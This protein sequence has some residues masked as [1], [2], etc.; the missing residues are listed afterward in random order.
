MGSNSRNS[1]TDRTLN[2]PDRTRPVVPTVAAANHQSDA[3]SVRSPATGRVRSQFR[4]PGT[5]LYSIGR[6]VSASGRLP[7]V[8]S[9][10][11]RSPVCRATGPAS[12]RTSSVR[13][14]RPVASASSFLHDLAYGLVP[15]FMLGLGLIF[16]V[17]SCASKVLLEVLI[18]RSSRH[19]RPSH[20]LHPIRLQN[21]HLQIH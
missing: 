5:S 9:P 11:V 20:V 16:W 13:S 10:C 1:A 4:A 15:I 14:L 7:P 21:K 18:I 12:G 8:S 3:A 6:C 17:F 2:R 19:L